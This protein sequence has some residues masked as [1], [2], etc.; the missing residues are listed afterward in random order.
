VFPVDA[1]ETHE[2]LLRADEALYNAKRAGKGRAA[3]WKAASGNKTGK[4][5]LSPKE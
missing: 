3:A 4:I 5:P 2:L 1:D